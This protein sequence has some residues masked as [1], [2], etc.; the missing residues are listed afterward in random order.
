MIQKTAVARF[1]GGCFW[2]MEAE[3]KR[4][5]GV[6]KT[7][8]G[9]EGGVTENPAYRDVCGGDTGH[10]EALEITYDPEKISYQDLLAHFLTR[11]HDPT[12]KDGQGPDTGT[13]YRSVIFY[14]DENQKVQAQKVIDTVNAGGQWPGPIVTT[15]EPHTHF[16]PAEDAHQDYYARYEAAHGQPHVNFLYKQRKWARQE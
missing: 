14:E 13:Q 5:D 11:A 1:G 12:Q 3:F 15:L 10:A 2:C 7:L 6:L 8:C 9:Y 16:W 4:L